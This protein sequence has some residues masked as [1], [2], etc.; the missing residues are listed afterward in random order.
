[1]CPASPYHGNTDL[2]ALPFPAAACCFYGQSGHTIITIMKLL[3][4]DFMLS[5]LTGPV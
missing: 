1:M 4:S 2:F 5:A 3:Y